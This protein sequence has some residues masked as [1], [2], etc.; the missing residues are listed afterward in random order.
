LL[1][2]QTA[3]GEFLDDLT[4]ANGDVIEL[5]HQLQPA[6]DVWVVIHGA[7]PRVMPFVGG[8][9]VG[10]RRICCDVREYS[11]VITQIVMPNGKRHQTGLHVSLGTSD[12]KVAT[13]RYHVL[14]HAL[15]QVRT[16]VANG[17]A[18]KPITHAV[19]IPSF[20]PTFLTKWQKVRTR[21]PKDIAGMESRLFRAE[22]FFEDTP[23]HE[24]TTKL[25]TQWMERLQQNPGVTKR[26]AE[27]RVHVRHAG[28]SASQVS[29]H[30]GAVGQ[31]LKFARGEG[32][33]P[34]G[35]DPLQDVVGRPQGNKRDTWWL[36]P[37]KALA[38]IKAADAEGIGP[39][40]RVLLYTDLRSKELRGLLVGD[41]DLAEGILHVRKN[42]HTRRTK[43]ERSTR[44]VPIWPD[45]RPTLERLVA[46]RVPDELLFGSDDGSMV[47]NVPIN[48]WR[49]AAAAAGANK[50]E[51]EPF[52]PHGCR[53]TYISQR[54]QCL[55]GGVPVSPFTVIKEVG[56]ATLKLLED[57]YGH[58]AQRRVRVEGFSYDTNRLQA[59]E[60]S[61]RPPA[62]R[63]PVKRYRAMI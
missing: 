18:A 5:G 33:V 48:A 60:S 21:E 58:V 15:D 37:H 9:F 46:N 29:Q 30:L 39:I 13:K 26:E 45:L 23:L 44:R 8:M 22:Q 62:R 59:V 12:P 53:H 20:T 24:L 25:L 38:F 61:R 19:T 55:D 57:R 43:T 51:N 28:L 47:N 16:D 17:I 11:D 4:G 42:A 49:R 7:Y 1:L 2:G 52:T 40:A 6:V 27:Q 54:L 32:H 34:S 14:V 41:I 56:H 31:L 63:R 35:F 3:A 36:E 50:S 10:R